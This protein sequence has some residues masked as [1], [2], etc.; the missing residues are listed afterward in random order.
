M[1]GVRSGEFL[2]EVCGDHRRTAR[3][4]VR[5]RRAAFQDRVEYWMTFEGWR[6]M[7]PVARDFFAEGFL[8]LYVDGIEVAVADVKAGRPVSDDSDTCHYVL[9]GE[10]EAL[11]RGSRRAFVRPC[12]CRRTFP[13]CDAP[14]DVC[15][16]FE[17]NA[18][19][20]GWEVSVE[21]A[22]R[23]LHDAERAGLPFTTADLERGHASWTSVRRCPGG[24]RTPRASPAPSGGRRRPSQGPDIAATMVAGRSVAASHGWGRPRTADRTTRTMRT[25]AER[26]DLASMDQLRDDLRHHSVRP[27]RLPRGGVAGNR[28]RLPGQP[29]HD[30][31]TCH[32]HRRVRPGRC[33]HLAD[34][35]APVP[36]GAQP[37]GRAQT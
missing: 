23:S 34:R 6:D 14:T 25:S 31:R 13:R 26:G 19:E 29:A 27:A 11:V 30:G 10:A 28:D 37:R 5:R 12:V 2:R 1:P 24:H 32:L 4:R 9:F 22:L 16:W 36:T 15:L 33:D 3:P 7:S 20:A 35:P 8:Q 21:G 18:R 17:D